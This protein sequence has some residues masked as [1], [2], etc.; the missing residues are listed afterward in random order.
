MSALQEYYDAFSCLIIRDCNYG[1][2][3]KNAII[4]ADLALR[5]EIIRLNGA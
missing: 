5:T 1:G 4:Q 3:A 2:N